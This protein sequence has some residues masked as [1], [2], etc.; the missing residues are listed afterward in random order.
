V[1]SVLLQTLISARRGTTL[2]S[3]PE[4]KVGPI[5]KADPIGI[6]V[7]GS[8]D[9]QAARARFGRLTGMT[10]TNRRDR[11][12]AGEAGD[13]PVVISPAQLDVV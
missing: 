13:L 5:R 9:R 6:V 7:G 11:S 8:G 1:S 4:D 10:V 2:A 12:K 3:I